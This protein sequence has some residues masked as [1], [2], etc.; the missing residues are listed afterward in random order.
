[1]E[2]LNGIFFYPGQLDNKI[3]GSLIIEKNKPMV[4]KLHGTFKMMPKF[5]NNHEITIWGNLTDGRVVSLL[6]CDSGFD[7]K[8]HLFVSEEEF[9]V[10]IAVIGKHVLT[11][12]EPTFYSVEAEINHLSDWIRFESY[13][14]DWFARDIDRTVKFRHPSNIELF[15]TE[16]V[17]ATILRT[18]T[19][20]HAPTSIKI[21]QKAKLLFQTRNLMSLNI[22]WDKVASF[23]N[24]ISLF[25]GERVEIKSMQFNSGQLNGII[26]KVSR[27]YE[28]SLVFEDGGEFNS[29]KSHHQNLVDYNII[30]D[31]LPA[32][33]KF[34]FDSAEKRIEPLGNILIYNLSYRKKFG[35][36][37]F[38]SV[39][40]LAEAYHRRVLA[41]A[42]EKK[43]EYEKEYYQP[44]LECIKYL[45][46]ASKAKKLMKRLFKHAHEPTAA[47][48]LKQMFDDVEDY[49][50]LTYHE[51]T[52]LTW[53]E[54]ITACRNYLIHFD[55]SGLKNKLPTVKMM[56]YTELLKKMM[57]IQLYRY[58]NLNDQVIKSLTN[59]QNFF[60]NG[61]IT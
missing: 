54:E 56:A 37:D 45:P 23:R 39:C 38:I 40:Q 16:Y 9:Y 7:A 5:Q 49:I 1:M 29:L 13:D 41:I 22:L 47:N 44:I 43:E 30:K 8:M 27:E 12:V 19:L 31:Y 35:E 15:S 6:N 53:A 34:W 25:I 18:I 46:N 58:L 10:T 2:N 17:S 59:S 48:R 33:T 21:E 57:T 42:H 51:K 50:G 14:I 55:E 28:P 61:I 24:L 11:D 52:T 3:N 20:S 32:I 26:N 60:L 4:L 36:E